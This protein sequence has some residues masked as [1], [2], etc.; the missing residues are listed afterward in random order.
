[1]WIGKLAYMHFTY[2]S[3][4]RKPQRNLLANGFKKIY[5]KN[6]RLRNRRAPQRIYHSGRDNLFN[7]RFQERRTALRSSRPPNRLDGRSMALMAF[8]AVGLLGD[9]FMLYAL[10]HWIRDDGARHR[11]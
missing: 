8:V 1:M 4:I 2:Q 5:K 9:G 7:V 11:C 3:F 6:L 10:L